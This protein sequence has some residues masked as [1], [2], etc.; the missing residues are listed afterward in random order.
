MTERRYPLE[1]LK[2]RAGLNRHQLIDALHISGTTLAR[3]RRN[4][5]TDKEADTYA[6]RL[7]YLPWQIWPTYIDDG[8]HA[9]WDPDHPAVPRTVPPNMGPSDAA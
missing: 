8:L 2:L 5:L 1:P 6:T 3:L 9:T 4:G 7:G